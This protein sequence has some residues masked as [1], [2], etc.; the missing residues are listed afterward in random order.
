[1]GN[2]QL[3]KTEEK[4]KKEIL[5][6]IIILFNF[7]I[8]VGALIFVTSYTLKLLSPEPEFCDYD[9]CSQESYKWNYSGSLCFYSN[10]SDCQDLICK[11][12]E[13]KQGDSTHKE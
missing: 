2:S 4:D 9:S 10:N 6:L 11:F 12:C 1:M 7:F 3:N 5:Y 13:T 8:L